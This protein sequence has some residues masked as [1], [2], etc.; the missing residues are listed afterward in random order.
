MSEELLVVV[1]DHFSVA[2][3]GLGISPPL[4][5]ERFPS[6]VSKRI[7]ARVEHEGMVRTLDALLAL[8]H[9]RPLGYRLV[10]WFPRATKDDVPRGAR[11]Y[12]VSE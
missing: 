7:V 3:R 11:I 12:E 9:F 6:T 5:P 4:D 2:S 8:E 10:I 1:E